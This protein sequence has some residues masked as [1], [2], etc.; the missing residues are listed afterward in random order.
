MV[1]VPKKVRFLTLV[2]LLVATAAAFAVAADF[3]YVGSAK[4]NKYHY[5]TCQWAQK[6]KPGNMVTFASVE[7]ARSAGYIPCKVCRPPAKD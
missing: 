4:S 3:K 2:F 5:P 6:I 1:G 7:V